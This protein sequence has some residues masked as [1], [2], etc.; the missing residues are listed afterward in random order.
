MAGTKIGGMKASA[1]VIEK[2]GRGF[3]REIGRKGDRMGILVDLRRTE[4]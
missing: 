3:Y 4:S 2:Y 1:T